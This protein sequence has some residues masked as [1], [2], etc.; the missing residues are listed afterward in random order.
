MTINALICD[1]E[2]Q[3]REETYAYLK[4]YCEE[5]C[6]N[7]NCDVFEK[8]EAA[9]NSNKK[10]NIAFLD[11]EMDSLNGI[12]VAGHLRNN[13]NNIIIFFITAHE[14]YIDDAMNFYAL[15]FMN[16]PIDCS[17]FYSG[18]DRAIELIDEGTLTVTVNDKHNLVSIETNT[19]L[20][21]EIY[22]HRVKLVTENGT[23]YV[24]ETLE[25]I[26][27]KLTH[28]SFVRV[29]KSFIVNLDFMKNYKRDYIEL[30][31]GTIISI[32]S[33]YQASFRKTIYSYFKRRK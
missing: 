15:R 30:K 19:L 24:S 2:K 3:S 7:C 20:Y 33:R 25:E 5:H 17:R 8:G 1:D 16:K 13:N 31:D 28:S 18:M 21:A 4:Q 22:R 26:E 12:D 10:Y 32:S 29:H 27:R 14:K 9:I 6:L 23:F 11:I